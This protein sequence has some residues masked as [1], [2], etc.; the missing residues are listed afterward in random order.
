MS[1][2][3]RRSACGS[4][5]TVCNAGGAGPVTT[6]A[7]RSTPRSPPADSTPAKP[8]GGWQPATPTCSRT[9]DETRR[10]WRRSATPIRQSPPTPSGQRQLLWTKAGEPQ[11]EW[12]ASRGLRPEVLRAN[13]VGADPGRRYLPRP[14]GLPGGWPAV[15]YPCAV[16]DRRASPTC[17]P[18]TWSRRPTGPSTTTRPPAWP[19]TRGWRGPTRRAHH[20]GGSSCAKAPPTRLIAAQAGFAAVGVLGATYPDRPRRRRDRR[21]WPPAPRTGAAPGGRLLRRRP[22]RR[23]RRLELVELLTE[24]D[25]T[26]SERRPARRSA[27]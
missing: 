24:R 6:V 13:R 11:R 7:P 15:V 9:L 18:A 14:K 27:T 4:P 12:L 8:S 2:S 3:T 21:R 26:D 10:R 16:T 5:L 20:D 22:G 23:D 1:T 17:R 19:P 25:I